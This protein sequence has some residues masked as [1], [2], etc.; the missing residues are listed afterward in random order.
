MCSQIVLNSKGDPGGNTAGSRTQQAFHAGASERRNLRVREGGVMRQV[1]RKHRA[2]LL[3]CIG[4]L[5]GVGF[6][7]SAMAAPSSVQVCTQVL[8]NGDTNT[9]EGGTWSYSVSNASVT[10]QNPSTSR[11]ESQSASAPACAAAAA[12]PAGSTSLGVLQSPTSP[13]NWLRNAPGYPQ[14]V[15]SD[16]THTVT[17]S[18]VLNISG[19]AYSQFAGATTVTFTNASGRLVS[20][21]CNLLQDNATAPSGQAGTFTLSA[22]GVSTSLNSTE[23]GPSSCDAGFQAN[24]PIGATAL[25]L[26]DA[27]SFVM[28]NGYPQATVV[29]AGNHSSSA[30]MNSSNGVSP[31]SGS[32]SLA[33]TAGDVTVNFTNKI[34]A[35][36]SVTI[37]KLL[38]D[39][40]DGTNQGGLNSVVYNTLGQS[41][42]MTVTEGSTTPSCAAPVPAP[43]SDTTTEVRE[44]Q[45]SSAFQGFATGY[46]KWAIYDATNPATPVL[47]GNG[48]VA[49]IPW[50]NAALS[51]L[52]AVR[53][54]FTDKAGAFGNGTQANTG[55]VTRVCKYVQDNLDGVAQAG[56]F[57]IYGNVPNTYAYASGTTP[58]IGEGTLS[59]PT[60][61]ARWSASEQRTFFEP[62]QQGGGWPGDAAGFPQLKIYNVANPTPGNT[63]VSSAQMA[64]EE[65][66]VTANYTATTAM[67]A[68][69]TTAVFVNQAGAQSGSAPKAQTLTFCMRVDDNGLAPTNDGGSWGFNFPVSGTVNATENSGTSCL[70]PIALPD[71]NGTWTQSD[72]QESIALPASWPGFD[73]YANGTPVAASPYALYTTTGGQSGQL[74]ASA[75]FGPYGVPV[76]NWSQPQSFFQGLSGNLTVTIVA[77][78]SARYQVCG[79][80]LQNGDST[81]DSNSFI[82]GASQGSTPISATKTLTEG[83]SPQC[84]SVIRMPGAGSFNAS[85]TL[86]GTWDTSSNTTGFPKWTITSNGSAPLNQVGSGLTANNVP[87]APAAQQGDTTITFSNRLGQLRFARF[88]KQLVDNADATNDS[89]TFSLA[90]T[91]DSATTPSLGTYPLTVSESGGEVCSSPVQVPVDA[92][93]LSVVENLPSGFISGTGY[94]RWLARRS[95]GSTAASGNGTSTGNVSLNTISASPDFDIVFRNQKANDADI[96]VT[97]TGPSSVVAGNTVTYSIAVHNAGPI[98]VPSITLA[99]PTPAGLTF[100]SATAPCTAG[101][102]CTLSNTASGA[103][104]TVTATYSVPGNYLLAG[105]SATISNKAT[106]TS[107][108]PDEVPANNTSTATTS[109]TS[110]TDLAITKSGPSSVAAGT[111]ITYT[112][113]I[114][115]SGPSAGDGASYSDVVPAGITNVAATC[116]SPLGGAVCATPTVSGNTVSGKVTTLP[117]SGSVTITITGKA[118]A[119]P[120]TLTNTATVTAPAGT[121]DPNTTNNSST[122]TTTVTNAIAISATVDN[123]VTYIAG[124]SLV[125]YAITVSNAGPLTASGVNVSNPLPTNLVGATWTC[126]GSGGATCTAS[127]SGAITDTVSLPANGAVHYALTGTVVKLPEMPITDKVTVTPTTGSPVVATETTTVGIFANG[128]ESAALGA[129]AVTAATAGADDTLVIPLEGSAAENTYPSPTLVG[130]VTDATSERAF[131]VHVL[132]IGAH[133]M[134]RLSARNAEG[135]WEPG[136]WN[137]VTDA[138]LI[139]AWAMDDDQIAQTPMLHSA[140]LQD[141]EVFKQTMQIE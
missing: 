11:N 123:G 133:R 116:G 91:S 131:A 104:V 77:R 92:N 69:D 62:Y 130:I 57:T 50:G 39:N 26:T 59:C 1:E 29:D 75:L 122:V 17:G 15:V 10:Y 20:K 53:V 67:P 93:N 73:T 134:A 47:S 76:I 45:L 118:P 121:T 34:S 28:E 109:V 37:C 5:A 8:N 140:Q 80:V 13:G 14:W 85:E 137:L 78:P 74:D 128:F 105:G 56:S 23:G 43:L 16:G 126:S 36:R 22:D 90:V 97:K 25:A 98:T 51:N 103:T 84:V 55:A 138:P 87:Q 139:L 4:L 120:T 88:C 12:P 141:G 95:D 46:P 86:P 60:T 115:N 81:D 99:D 42:S 3:S 40:A 101:F 58:T 112:L 110:S 102:P 48:T 72:F 52:Q 135:V 31:Y 96:S 24:V 117:K 106:V 111:S 114:G 65:T 124:G 83:Q 30:V 125:D 71:P 61:M 79:Q 82:L 41:V 18:G 127:G 94:P 2:A 44:M 27:T 70:A 33:G 136:S 119:S 54:V 108:T 64:F 100:V 21:V 68:G 9:T 132:D 49:D 66:T 89:G 35:N 6:H 32:V 38:E 129:K 19:G 107:S 63:P 113:L 7:A